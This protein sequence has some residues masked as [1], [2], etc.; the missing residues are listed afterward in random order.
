MVQENNKIAPLAVL[1]ARMG[2]SRLPGKTMYEINGRPMIDYVL[3]SLLTIFKKEQLIIVTSIS[4]NNDPIRDYA[5]KNNI[6]VYSGHEENVASRYFDVLNERNEIS[7]MFRFCADTPLYDM[8]VVKKGLE[9]IGSSD[10]EV[11]TSIPNKGF[12]MGCNVEIITRE[13]F[14]KGYS[15]FSKPEHFEHVMGYFYENKEEFNVQFVSCDAKDYSYEKVKFSVDTEEDLSMIIS[16]LKKMNYNP[17]NYSF[18]DKFE[19]LKK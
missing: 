8:S 5:F 6:S 3:E 7:H 15:Q 18:S 19:L 17:L 4:S 12:P 16:V 11:V 2:S 14:M 10:V 9:V 1:Q 13:V